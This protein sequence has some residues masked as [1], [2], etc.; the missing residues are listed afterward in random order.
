[1]SRSRCRC[2]GDFR[3]R[4]ETNFGLNSRR[5]LSRGACRRFPGEPAR[6]LLSFHA[7][8]QLTDQTYTPAWQPGSRITTT[9]SRRRSAAYLVVVISAG[10]GLA[11]HAPHAAPPPGPRE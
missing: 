7:C 10:K 9:T 1:M 5:W 4:E 2:V 3:K 6:S 8:E 11:I